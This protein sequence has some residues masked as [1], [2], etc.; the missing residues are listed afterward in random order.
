VDLILPDHVIKYP[1]NHAT[2]SGNGGIVRNRLFDNSYIA[3]S[4]MKL[5]I[6]GRIFSGKH[7]P[8]YYPVLL[9]S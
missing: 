6:P 3:F 9:I 2:G 8:E 5:A 7:A 4:W 1:A